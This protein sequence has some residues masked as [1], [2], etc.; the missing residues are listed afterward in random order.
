[1]ILFYFEKFCAFFVYA[2]GIVFYG[3]GSPAQRTLH[4]VEQ[5]ALLQYN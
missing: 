3:W 4:P 5:E 1:M 2:D